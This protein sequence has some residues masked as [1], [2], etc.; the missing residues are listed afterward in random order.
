LF[1]TVLKVQSPFPL[2]INLNSVLGLGYVVV[3]IDE[4]L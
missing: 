4:L 3:S 2:A 1:K